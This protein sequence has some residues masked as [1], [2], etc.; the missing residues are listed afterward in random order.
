MDQNIKVNFIKNLET[1]IIIHPKIKKL[2]EK[3]LRKI[4]SIKNFYSKMVFM[5]FEIF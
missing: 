2:L 4:S 5:V 1:I 3:F